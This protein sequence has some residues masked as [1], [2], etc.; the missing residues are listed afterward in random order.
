MN[1]LEKKKKGKK[2]QLVVQNTVKE[3]ST[4]NLDILFERFFRLD[5]SRNS[6]TGGSGIGLSIVKAIV[7]RH[8]GKVNAKSEDGK[9]LRIDI[10]L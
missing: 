9:S 10:L 4:G 7:E 8:G 3:I 1:V 6:K 2:H 5:S